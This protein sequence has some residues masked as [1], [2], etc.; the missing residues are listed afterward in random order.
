MKKYIISV[1]LCTSL[2]AIAQSNVT[3]QA[4]LVADDKGNIL[5]GTHTTDVRSIASITKLMTS[6]VVLDS[7]QSL[8]ETIPKKLYNRTFTR[9]ELLNLAIV[10]SDNNAAKML[11]EYYPGGTVKCIEAMNNK[12]NQLNMYSS[13]FT[14][15]TGLLKTNVSTAEDLIKL[16]MAAKNYPTIVNASN[17]STIQWQINKNK[18]AIFHNTNTLVGKGVDFIVSKTGWITASGG[19]IVMMLNGDQGIRTVVLLGSKN[20]H[21]RIPEAYMLS[22]LH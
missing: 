11:C 13:N 18:S 7:N 8:S 22:K 15:P 16:V 9:R 19:C 10:K 1:I 5:E 14:D 2:C 17:T 21:T 4:W 20:T 3:A 12:A 6:M